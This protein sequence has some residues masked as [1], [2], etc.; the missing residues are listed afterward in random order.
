MRF[1]LDTNILIDMADGVTATL[2]R[3]AAIPLADLAM[4]AI[5][6]AELEASIH[7]DPEWAAQREPPTR[8][9]L[10]AIT[11][12]PFTAA[13]AKAYGTIVEACGY[14]RRKAVDR[15]IA[16][17]AIENGLAV[18]TRNAADFG[19]MPGLVVEDWGVR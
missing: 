16:A 14:N 11:I 12:L 4:A 6:A 18:V 17:T 9:V 13:T 10:N 5:S 8:A 7:A 19:G 2:D 3:I 1:L 15:L